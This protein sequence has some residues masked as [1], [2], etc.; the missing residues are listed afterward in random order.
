MYIGL[1]FFITWKEFAEKLES[2][3]KE[4]QKLFCKTLKDIRNKKRI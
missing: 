1:H 2:D 3:T 4:N